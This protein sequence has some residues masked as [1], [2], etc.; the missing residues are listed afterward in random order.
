[1]SICTEPMLEMCPYGTNVFLGSLI[2]VLRGCKLMKNALKELKGN[3]E[4]VQ[5]CSMN[6]YDVL[7]VC[8][9]W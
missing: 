1:M 6:S 5:Q 4:Y 8:Q 7:V 9:S 3:D 2:H